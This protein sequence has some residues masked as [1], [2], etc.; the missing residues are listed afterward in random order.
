MSCAS[1][2]GAACGRVDLPPWVY[3]CPIVCASVVMY[4]LVPRHVCVCLHVC[5]CPSVC[6][7]VCVRS[8]ACMRVCAS[9]CHCA[10]ACGRFRV[11]VCLCTCVCV[12][13]CARWLGGGGVWH[14]VRMSSFPFRMLLC[15]SVCASACESAPICV[16]MRVYGRPYFLTFCSLGPCCRGDVLWPMQARNYCLSLPTSKRQQ[17][18]LFHALSCM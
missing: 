14:P 15:G 6:V 9:V 18:R 13:M 7:C 3:G 5:L 1:Q 4:S 17:V 16:R 11:R 8:H 12:C 2:S 10:R